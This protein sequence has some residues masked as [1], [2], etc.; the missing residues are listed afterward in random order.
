MRSDSAR[1][2]QSA[3][4]E[5]LGEAATGRL[6][7]ASAVV[8]A[9]AVLLSLFLPW[10]EAPNDSAYCR[11]LI[12]ASGIADPRGRCARL[13]DLHVGLWPFQSRAFAVVLSSV[14]VVVAAEA[15][16]RA[17]CRSETRSVALGA[18]AAVA[19]PVV[20]AAV[21]HLTPEDEPAWGAA[22]GSTFALA[23]ALFAAAGL[24][25]LVAAGFARRGWADALRPRLL[26][27]LHRGGGRVN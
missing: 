12:V 14:L 19:L 26:A 5:R 4:V 13:G 25:L 9:V 6:S 7:Y 16:R 23:A 20:V 1:P 2:R 22:G 21:R 10:Y 15:L 24:I 8:G 3:A 27:R 11:A 17:P 18:I